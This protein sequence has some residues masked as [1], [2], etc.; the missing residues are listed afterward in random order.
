M[1]KKIP[2]V[3]QADVGLGKVGNASEAEQ[4]TGSEYD[5]T[6]DQVNSYVSI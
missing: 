5:K 6:P 4:A 2:P 1:R 3:L